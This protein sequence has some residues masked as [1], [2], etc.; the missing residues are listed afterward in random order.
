MLV[1]GNGTG[2]RII[3]HKQALFQAHVQIFPEIFCQPVNSLFGVD[4]SESLA[5]WCAYALSQHV[6]E[7]GK[8]V[9]SAS[10]RIM[11]VSRTYAELEPGGSVDRNGKATWG[12]LS[13]ANQHHGGRLSLVDWERS[14]SAFQGSHPRS[15]NLDDRQHHFEHSAGVNYR[16]SS[17]LPCR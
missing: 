15:G 5:Q 3:R 1:A 7:K 14:H 11:M 8:A 4:P 12:T 16:I 6:P 2:I 9:R 17:L 13:L 10:A